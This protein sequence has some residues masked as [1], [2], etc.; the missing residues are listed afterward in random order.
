MHPVLW[1]PPPTPPGL[2]AN[3]CTQQTCLLV[4]TGIKEGF[5][6]RYDYSSHTCKKLPKNMQSAREGWAAINEY[7]AQECAEGRILGQFVEQSLPQL[8]VSRLGV[9]PKH[10]PGL[11]RLIVDLSS[12][13]GHRVN[14]GISRS[15][16]SLTY[17]S[18]D[19]A[20]KL[21]EQL[22]Q[23]QVKVDIRSAYRM[24]PIH[25]DDRWFLGMRWEGSVFVDTALP[26]GLQ[27]A[28]KIFTAIADALE[29]IV[30][31]EGVSSVIHYLDDFLE[32]RAVYSVH[33]TSILS[34]HLSVAWESQLPPKSWKAR[35][36]A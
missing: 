16:C 30:K 13:D 14:D 21:V 29:W 24:L 22:G 4:V 25:P 2:Q 26:F 5:G 27:S 3:T 15:L 33:V 18:V 1:P 32:C 31:F 17:V 28:P 34:C 36:R 6:V 19:T 12:P 7:L 8:Q 9:V 10:T 20:V 35:P 23:G 11:K